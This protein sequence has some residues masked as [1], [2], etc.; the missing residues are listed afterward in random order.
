ML[1]HL[2]LSSQQSNM[3]SS[4]ALFRICL[5]ARSRC[6]STYEEIYVTCPDHDN[7]FVREWEWVLS[8]GLCV[9]PKEQNSQVEVFV[10]YWY[11][12]I[13]WSSVPL[14]Y[15]SCSTP[16]VHFEVSKPRER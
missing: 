16:L 2:A 11:K 1:Y 10:T 3:F 5:P 6:R 8:S 4:A 13:D 7:M 12:E 15:P 9:E 14:K